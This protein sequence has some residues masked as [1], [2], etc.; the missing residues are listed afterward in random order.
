MAV[1]VV[2]GQIGGAELLKLSVDLPPQL[3][4]KTALEE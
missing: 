2:E 1:D 4:A 3:R